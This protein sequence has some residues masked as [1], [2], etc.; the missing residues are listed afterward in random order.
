[1]DAG[2]IDVMPNM[3]PN[4]RMQLQKLPNEPRLWSISWAKYTVSKVYREQ[5]KKKILMTPQ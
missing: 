3:L 4:S 1:M 5:T 2:V